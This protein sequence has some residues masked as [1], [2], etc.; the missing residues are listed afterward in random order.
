MNYLAHIQLAHVSDTSMLGNFLGDFVKGS[1]LSHLPIE[2]QHGI[3]L[4]RQIDTYT[5]RHT[6]VRALREIFPKSIRRMSGVVIDIYFDHLLCRHWS[7]FNEHHLDTLLDAFYLE[8]EQHSKPIG[9]RFTQVK[10]GLIEYRWLSDYQ[11]I[12]N[13]ERALHQIEK[14]LNGK[15]LFAQEAVQFVAQNSAEF[16]Q[17]FLRFYPDL[18]NYTVLRANQVSI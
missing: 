18:I 14:R 11:E 5:D 12:A 1:D 7:R 2:H 10:E 17:R 6:E 16:E 3:R 15:V 13:C 4:H 9:G 8:I